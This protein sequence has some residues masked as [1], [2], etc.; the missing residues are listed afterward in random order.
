L[1]EQR[2]VAELETQPCA[3]LR[4][5]LRQLRRLDPQQAVKVESY[6]GRIA[7]ARSSEE[8][9][10]YQHRRR[11]KTPRDGEF[12]GEMVQARLLLAEIEAGREARQPADLAVYTAEVRPTLGSL[13]RRTIGIDPRNCSATELEVYIQR[14]RPGARLDQLPIL[15]TWPLRYRAVAAPTPQPLAPSMPARFAAG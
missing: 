15:E 11:V 7:R 3:A 5:H 6:I 10:K 1:A 13:L 12:S 4:D 8:W 2:I 14:W 9:V